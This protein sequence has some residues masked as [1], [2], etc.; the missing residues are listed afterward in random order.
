MPTAPTPAMTPKLM[1]APLASFNDPRI[2]NHN[3]SDRPAILPQ[4]C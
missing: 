3:G 1:F 2:T 4:L